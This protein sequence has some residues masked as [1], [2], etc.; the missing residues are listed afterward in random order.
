ML[1]ALASFQ[2]Q[3][4]LIIEYYNGI[5]GDSDDYGLNINDN[6]PLFIMACAHHLTA[7]GHRPC[8]DRLYP[9][10]VKA[11]KYI[12]SQ[13]DDRE[14]VF[15]TA[16]GTGVY[17]IAGWRNII[18]NK[19][20]SGAVTEINSECYAALR[21]V[22]DIAASIGR[23]DD[24]D[25]FSREADKLR[26]A[27]NKHLLNP[28]N[29]TYYLNIDPD[30]YAHA[31]VTADEV[32][33][34]L[35]GVSDDDTSRLISTR[36]SSP[37]FMT[38]GGL[39]TVPSQNPLYISDKR[40]GLEGG[41]WPG[42]TWWYAMASAT[43]DPGVMV[44]AL[45]S[46]YQHYIQDPGVHNTVPG[47]FSEWFDGESLVNRG[48]RLSPWEPP[49]F[50]WALLEGAVGLN[51]GLKRLAVNPRIPPDWRWLI[52]RN[53]P[54]QGEL[55]SFFM[56]RRVDGI[57]FFTSSE[58]DSDYHVERFETDLSDKV[59]PLSADM[60]TS[61]FG[62]D[63]EVLICLASTATGKQTG[64]FAVKGLFELDQEYKVSVYASETGD[65]AEIGPY[66][67]DYLERMSAWIEPGGF[68]LLRITR[69]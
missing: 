30:D 45:R 14:L 16:R 13:E 4:G 64:A 12:I 53:L 42:V 5:S 6:T 59:R 54:Y 44:K 21:A 11:A 3:N 38:A 56:G 15:C 25:Y 8:L 61:A 55:V 48:M 29:G 36:L 69:V 18:E 7:T 67:G 66:T 47:Q 50:L 40:I 60:Y 33:P 24:H 68:S 57:Y 10:M 23:E 26:D 22:A 17:G 9:A 28:K 51:V 58:F 20:I 52:L 19:N 43:T 49:R 63:D 27:I 34:L 35:C 46:S 31:E 37:D 39:R 65:W 41:V 2:K 62:R 1:A 32:F